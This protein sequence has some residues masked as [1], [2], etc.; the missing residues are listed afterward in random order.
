MRANGD[1]LA[2][3]PSAVLTDKNRFLRS[4]QFGAGTDILSPDA[5]AACLSRAS[6]TAPPDLLTWL[7]RGRPPSRISTPMRGER[8]RRGQRN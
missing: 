8:N 7:H 3:D 4:G 5:L 2:P 6:R 1:A